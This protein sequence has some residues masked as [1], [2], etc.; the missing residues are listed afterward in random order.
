MHDIMLTGCSSIETQETEAGR[1]HR[2]RLR[3][4]VV[5]MFN[6]MLPPVGDYRKAL[7][8]T[9]HTPAQKPLLGDQ[10][11]HTTMQVACYVASTALFSFSHTVRL[12]Q[13]VV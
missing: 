9:T 10:P 6:C 3:Q 12:A 4:A 11:S 2:D 5:F 7:H 1:L 8:L 13:E